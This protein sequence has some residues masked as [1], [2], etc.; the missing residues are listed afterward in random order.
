MCR[1]TFSQVVEVVYQ[2]D[3]D[4]ITITD[5]DVDLPSLPK[6]YNIELK[7]GFPYNNDDL[8]KSLLTNT[9]IEYDS[10]LLK[11]SYFISDIALKN[12]QIFRDACGIQ[13]SGVCDGLP[14]LLM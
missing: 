13:V 8:L 7:N 14:Q 11:A 4:S 9:W 2:Q 6:Q 3:S 1:N 5:A 12:L 10:N